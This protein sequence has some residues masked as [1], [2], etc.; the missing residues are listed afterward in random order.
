MKNLIKLLGIIALVAV[1][2]FSLTGCP[3]EPGLST[4]SGNVTITPNGTVTVNTKLTAAYSGTETVTFQWYKDNTAISGETSVNYTP[5]TAGS[6]TVTVNRAGFNSK[7]SEA[8]TVN[9]APA[10]GD[11]AFSGTISISPDT[12]VTINT[13]LTATYS[14]SET[15]SYQ[16][17]KDGTVITGATSNKYTPTEA[18]S[19]TV[20]VS[21]A[22]YNPKTS[23]AVTVIAAPNKTLTSITAVYNSNNVIF[24]D[25]TLHTL[26]DDLTV[27][28]AYSDNTTKTLELE[29]YTLSGTLAEGNSII[30]VSYTESGITKTDTFT[31]TVHAA[32]VHAWGNWSQTTAPTCTEPGEEMR[33]CA[34]APPHSETRTGAAALGHDYQNWTQ[35]TA[36]TCTTAGVETG[37]CT[38]DQVT[39]TRTGAAALGHDYEWTET[40]APTCITAGVETGTCTRDQVTAIR[41]GT[42]AL[43]H[44]WNTETGL[45]NNNCGELYYNLG[46]TGPG[47]GKIFYVSTN[48][49]TMTDDNSTTHYLEAAPVDMLNLRWVAESYGDD[50]ESF[51]D[52]TNSPQGNEI[53]MGRSNTAHILTIDTDAPAAKACNEYTNNEKTD[54]FLPS[55]YELEQLYINRNSVDNLSL[56][57]YWSSSA[58]RKNFA[59]FYNFGTGDAGGTVKDSSYLVRPIRA[60]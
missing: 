53:G 11:P 38:R 13:E 57:I 10:S 29:D 50:Y 9:A 31:V 40:T 34:A 47:G 3:P 59:Y 52:I 60:F 17:Y 18:G 51:P 4:L 23:A 32:H 45:C 5:T 19:Y 49:F 30:T 22:G 54:W 15:V 1:I 26:K 12:G 27:T 2:G 56:A 43:G 48:G 8:V 6:Y 44:N 41:T 24:P 20:T 36:P 55:Y 28:A 58:Y 21:A 35:T 14:G 42:L 7:T 46:D 39:T 37:T 25:T 16:W 33:N